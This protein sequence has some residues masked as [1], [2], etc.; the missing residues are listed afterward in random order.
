MHFWGQLTNLRIDWPSALWCLCFCTLLY[1]LSLLLM[2]SGLFFSVSYSP[3]SLS[4]SPTL[5][6]FFFFSFS[7]APLTWSWLHADWI[8][9]A[10]TVTDGPPH[11]R[12][13]L[14]LE[15]VQRVPGS[16]V[17][18]RHLQSTCSIHQRPRWQTC[19]IFSQLAQYIKDPGDQSIQADNVKLSWL[20]CAKVDHG[21]HCDDTN[22][23]HILSSLR[24]RNVESWVALCV[25][26]DFGSQHT[27]VAAMLAKAGCNDF[28]LQMSVLQC[29][30]LSWACCRHVERCYWYCLSWGSFKRMLDCSVSWSSVL[31]SSGASPK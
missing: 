19:A 8:Q 22:L 7:A 27:F 31:L 11:L 25:R 1:C 16:H 28:P 18:R 10:V 23:H 15:C 17:W 20:W 30:M 21:M 13:L 5:F 2:F 3:S 24:V 9:M 6:F 26:S 29:I 4:S 12:A 14:L